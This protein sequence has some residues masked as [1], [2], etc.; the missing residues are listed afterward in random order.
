MRNL[1][2]ILLAFAPAW[3]LAQ[4]DSVET[5]QTT[6]NI[7]GQY[8]M[9]T[10]APGG[11]MSHGGYFALT[12]HYSRIM[13]QDAFSAGV[14][15]GYMM[16]HVFTLGFAGSGFV[17]DIPFSN[18]LPSEKVYLQG[19]YGGLLLEPVVGARFPV[20]VTFPVMIGGGAVLY[21]K[22]GFYEDIGENYAH[23]EWE[24]VDTDI[25]FV[26]EPGVN[27]EFNV[28]KFFRCGLEAK[29]RYANGRHLVTSPGNMLTG[30]SGG[31]T[32]KFGKF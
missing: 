31:L 16:N 19:G 27:L 4:K 32:L 3:L 18:I 14:R 2:F 30:W 8:E 22:E 28:A 29:Y 5:A 26:V 17:N 21:N 24:E 7:K 1:L 15:F 20:H 6:N 13:G 10:L 23:E 9:K 25:F 11:K 12:T